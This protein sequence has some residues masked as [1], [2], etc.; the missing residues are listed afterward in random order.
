MSRRNK[1]KRSKKRGR[2][3]IGRSTVIDKKKK[4]L[5]KL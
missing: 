3:R 5:N 1:G 2:K 4:W